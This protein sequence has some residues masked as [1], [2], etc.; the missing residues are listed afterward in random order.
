M[1]RKNQT[2]RIDDDVPAR[3]KAMA[4]RWNISQSDLVNYLL[5]GGLED[6]ENG[7]KRIPTVPGRAVVDFG[8]NA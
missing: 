5:L 8:N 6:L 4:A 1:A 3:L 2:F 7:R